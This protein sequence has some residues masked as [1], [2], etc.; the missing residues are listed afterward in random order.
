[1]IYKNAITPSVIC[2]KNQKNTAIACGADR[3]REMKLTKPQTAC[4]RAA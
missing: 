2:N 3:N 1:M 4:S